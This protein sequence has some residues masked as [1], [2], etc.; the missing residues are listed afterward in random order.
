M[1]NQQG[2]T[3]IELMIVVAIIGILAA[4]AIP[5]YQNYVARSKVTEG[6]NLASSA[7]ATVAEN[8]VVGVDPLDS[9]VNT[10]NV[11]TDIVSAM[12]VGNAGAITITFKDAEIPGGGSLILTPTTGTGNSASALAAGTPA[13]GSIQWNCTVDGLDPSYAPASCRGTAE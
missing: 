12:Q 5:Q 1:K 4:V 2:F 11:E 7:K 13:D 8:A 10:T 3:L 6:L 9:G